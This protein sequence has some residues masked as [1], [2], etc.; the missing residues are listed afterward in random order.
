MFQ[1][2]III[3]FEL[4]IYT[5]N[6]LVIILFKYFILKTFFF[7]AYFMFTGDI[8]YWRYYIEFVIFKW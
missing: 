6:T 2:I 4:I 8:I 1:L 3:E 7:Y 5:L